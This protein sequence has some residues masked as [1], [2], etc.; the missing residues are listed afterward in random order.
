MSKNPYNRL[1]YYPVGA[2]QMLLPLKHCNSFMLNVLRTLSYQ[3]LKMIKEKK[4]NFC[5]SGGLQIIE[6]SKKGKKIIVGPLLRTRNTNDYLTIGTIDNCRIYRRTNSTLALLVDRPVYTYDSEIVYWFKLSKSIKGRNQMLKAAPYLCPETELVIA[7]QA[8]DPLEV[9]KYF[10][11]IFTPYVRIYAYPTR[12][13][14]KPSDALGNAFV[15][16]FLSSVGIRHIHFLGSSA[17]VIMFLLAKAIALNMFEK[18]SFD[19][20]T[21]NQSAASRRLKYLHPYTLTPMPK[22]GSLHPNTNLRTELSRYN[23]VFEATIGRSN[24]PPWVTAK[25]WCGFYNIRAVEEFKNTVLSVA[26]DNNLN[27]FVKHFEKYGKKN[28]EE[29][30]KAL[31]LLDESK[32]FGH[33]YIKRKYQSKIEELYTE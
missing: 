9:P 31:D 7:I 10:S 19:S 16:S 22:K 30:L 23:G 2:E 25:E 27:Y 13:R 18:A 24:P 6:A 1:Q 15:L 33:D 28:K 29:I 12:F 11:W 21:W 14:N 32:D 5:D 4:S 3:K 8:R 26:L 17:P 20:L